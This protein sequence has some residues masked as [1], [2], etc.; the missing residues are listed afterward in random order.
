V[1]VATHCASASYKLA[2]KDISNKLV[3][4][5]GLTL[6]NGFSFLVIFSFFS[7]GRAAD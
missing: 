5:T 3:F 1:R 7:F 2:I 6:L 4:W